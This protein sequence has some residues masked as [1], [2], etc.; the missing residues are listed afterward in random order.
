MIW[1]EKSCDIFFSDDRHAPPGKKQVK[2]NEEE[3]EDLNEANF[4]EVF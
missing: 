1:D 2:D 4:D 3:E